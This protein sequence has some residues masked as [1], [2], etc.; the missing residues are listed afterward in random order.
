VAAMPVPKAQPAP[1]PA[2]RPA[3]VAPIPAAPQPFAARP[4][5]SAPVSALAAKIAAER[6]VN[7]AAVR[8]SGPGGR[9]T[10]GDVIA[11][12]EAGTAR[13]VPAAAAPPV[14][15][16]PVAPPKFDGHNM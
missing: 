2:A 3:A 12:A 5:A 11:A 8:G 4:A 6:G 9:I 10:K 7:L 13:F 16:G 14:A 1:Q 15:S